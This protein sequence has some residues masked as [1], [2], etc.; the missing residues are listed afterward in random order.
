MNDTVPSARLAKKLAIKAGQRVIV[1]RCPDELHETF[2]ELGA[3]FDRGTIAEVTVSFVRARTEVEQAAK[4]AL[5]LTG[6]QGVLWMCYPKKTGAIA[7][8]LSRDS[9][10]EAFTEKGWRIVSAIAVDDTWSALRFRPSEEV[11]RT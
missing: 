5:A 4:E 6:P 8:D 7:S 9:G 11:G 10:W 2:K 1:H 3:A